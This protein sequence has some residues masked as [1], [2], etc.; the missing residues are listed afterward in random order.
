MILDTLTNAD[1]YRNASD[2]L[3]AAFDFLRDNDLGAMETGR[4]EIQGDHV[5]ALVMD[6][7][8]KPKAGALWEAHRKYADVQYVVSGVERMG[9]ANVN[10]LAVTQAYDADKDAAMLEGEGSFF[11]VPSGTF[12]VF[13]PEDAHM[14]GLAVDAPSAVRK[15]V[16]KVSE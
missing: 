6:V 10:D 2:G 5:F 13:G 11:T 1:R 9:Y 4:H 12:V 7:E 3:A 15:V 16:V 8:T 14:P